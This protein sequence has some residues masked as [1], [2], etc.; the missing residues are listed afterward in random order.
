MRPRCIYKP[1]SHVQIAAEATI[2]VSR[3]K[4]ELFQNL[5]PLR[6]RVLAVSDGSKSRSG[7]R[8]PTP[9][10]CANPVLDVILFTHLD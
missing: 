6:H 3:L 1:N 9:T 8:V 4:R 5:D 7:G 10:R 2:M